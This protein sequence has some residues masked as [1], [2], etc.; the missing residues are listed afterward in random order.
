[1]ARLADGAVEAGIMEATL[2]TLLHT[3]QIN[4][5]NVSVKAR[6]LRKAHYTIWSTH[7]ILSVVTSSHN[8]V[9][10]CT[11]D[12]HRQVTAQGLSTIKW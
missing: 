4:K 3:Q 6:K 11:V 7:H 8:N 9:H 1:L 5:K 12:H 10:K 2:I